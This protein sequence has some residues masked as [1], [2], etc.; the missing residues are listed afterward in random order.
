MN[1]IICP[2]QRFQ[3]AISEVGLFPPQTVVA[4]GERKTFD[5]KIQGKEIQ[6]WY[7]L[8][9]DLQTGC[10]GVVGL[11]V[12]WDYANAKAQLATTPRMA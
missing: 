10:F 5:T 6:A 9:P 1:T 7:R 12:F 3:H 8:A 4:D 2:I 11:P